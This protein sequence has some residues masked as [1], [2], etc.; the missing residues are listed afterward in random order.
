M[1]EI[2]T[3]KRGDTLWDISFKYFGHPYAWPRIWSFNKQIQNPHW[4]YPG[5]HVRLREGGGVRQVGVGVGF[6]RLRPAVPS[7]AVFARNLGFVEDRQE[8]Y[9]GEIV[10]SPD[11]KMMLSEMDDVYVQ[12]DGKHAVDVGQQLTVFEPLDVSNRLDSQIVYVRGTLLVDRL[13]PKTNLARA[14]IVESLDV[15]A[16]GAKVGAVDRKIEPVFPVPNEQNVIASIV[17]SLY[18]HQFFGRDQALFIDKGSKDGVQVGNRFFVVVRGDEWR[19]GLAKAGPMAER[20]A[21]TDDD[22]MARVERTPPPGPEDAYPAE[23]YGEVMVVRVRQKTAL[24]LVTA[25]M[26]EIARDAV[27]IARKGY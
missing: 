22:T 27:L 19:K 3:V 7:N 10:G 24:C 13:N 17:G 11:D 4:L 14:R 5:D 2:H 20:R 12:L 9:W 25:A 1:P 8:P 23:T 21:V 15:I 26:R 16:R 18:P 6:V